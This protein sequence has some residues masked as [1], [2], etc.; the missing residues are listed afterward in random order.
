MQILLTPAVCDAPMAPRPILTHIHRKARVK[1]TA[2]CSCWI[3]TGV[4]WWH[5]K[6]ASGHDPHQGRTVAA[7]PRVY[8]LGTCLEITGLGR[9]WVED[10]GSAIKGGR[11][12]V[13]Y[14]SHRDAKRFGVRRLEVEVCS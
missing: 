4:N 3:C 12:D 7:D 13:Y 9:R 8:P 5:G 1:V 6:T 14:Y 2:Y 10:T 11:L